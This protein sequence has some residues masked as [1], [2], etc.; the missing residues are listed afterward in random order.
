VSSLNKE[1]NSD[2]CH[3]VGKSWLSEIGQRQ[4]KCVLL[5]VAVNM[6][7]LLGTGSRQVKGTREI[8]LVV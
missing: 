7:K 8:C 5:L 2:T 4:T 6:V 3:N 1:E